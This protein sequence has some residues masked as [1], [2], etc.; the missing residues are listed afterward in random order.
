M[1]NEQ[2]IARMHELL[3]DPDPHAIDVLRDHLIQHGLKHPFKIIGPA[4]ISFSGGRTSGFMLKKCIE[5]GIDDDVHVLFANTGKEREET[6]IFIDQ[7]EKSFGVKVRWIERDPDNDDGFREVTFE[8]A[9]RAGEPFARLIV[10]KNYL[11]NPVTRWCTTELKI[12]AMKHWM[13]AHGYKHWTDVVGLRADEPR[14]VAKT[15]KRNDSGG[16]WD[17]TLPL[18]DAGITVADVDAFWSR[19]C[20]D[21]RLRKWEGNCDLCFLKGQAKRVRIMHDRPDLAAWWVGQEQE[22]RVPRTPPRNKRP[23]PIASDEQPALFDEEIMAAAEQQ[24]RWP[25]SRS[26]PFRIDSPRYAELLARSQQPFL[27]FDQADLDGEAI[28]DIAD[29]F[30]N[31][32]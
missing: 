25:I 27:A 10:D 29:C 24:E 30:C 16:R 26:H 19:Q 18:A 12:R 13:M 31:A 21:L 22:E 1:T 11:P 2:A 8:T 23:E 14:R 7:C 20:F 9:S 32:A 3:R 17:V 4:K 28:D 5:A 6:L 15:R